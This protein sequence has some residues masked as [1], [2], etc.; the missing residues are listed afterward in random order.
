MA[1]VSP[2]DPTEHVDLAEKELDML[3]K[4]KQRLEEW[5]KSLVPAQN[6]PKD[7]KAD[8][9]NYDGVWTPGWC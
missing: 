5:M 2:D 6:P 1:C 7:P 8:P 4:M 9:K 3:Q